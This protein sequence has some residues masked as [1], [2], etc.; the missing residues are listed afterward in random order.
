MRTR[1]DAALASEKA[2]ITQA[3]HKKECGISYEDRLRAEPLLR[4]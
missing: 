4:F 1:I 3:R 2:A